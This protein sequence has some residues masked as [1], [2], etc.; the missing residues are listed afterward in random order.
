MF[1][2]CYLYSCAEEIIFHFGTL[3][4]SLIQIFIQMKN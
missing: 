3:H 4:D 2:K 1:Y